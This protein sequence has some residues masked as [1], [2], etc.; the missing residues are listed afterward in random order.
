MNF[1]SN[2]TT[3][4]SNIFKKNTDDF[5]YI[6]YSSIFGSI[7]LAISSKIQIPLAPVPVTLQTMVLLVMSMF[8]DGNLLWELL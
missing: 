6:L 3:L 4:V 7:L 2:D 1:I 8:W 5:F